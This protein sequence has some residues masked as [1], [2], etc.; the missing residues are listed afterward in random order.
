MTP[1]GNKIDMM[2]PEP[3][4]TSW[5]DRETHIPGDAFPPGLVAVVLLFLLAAAISVITIIGLIVMWV[6]K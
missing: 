4:E 6:L 3:E 1:R 2:W 5:S